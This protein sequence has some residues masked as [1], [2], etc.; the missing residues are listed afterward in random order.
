MIN[1]LNL[2]ATKGDLLNRTISHPTEPNVE[3]RTDQELE[4]SFNKVLPEILGGF[5][6]VIVKALKVRETVKVPKLF[7][8]ADFTQWGCALAVA[9]GETVEDFIEAMEENLAYQN[10]ADIENNV[11][12]DAFLSYCIEKLSLLNPTENK[13]LAAPPEKVFENVTS[14]AESMKIAT[15]S[16]R[17]PSA[18]CYFT[19]KLNDSKA[20][21]V[22]NHWNYEVAKNK[23]GK[24]EMSIWRIQE[25]PKEADKQEEAKAPEAQKTIDLPKEA[26]KQYCRE[27]CEN[28]RDTGCKKPNA[29]FAEKI[30]LSDM[31]EIP[32]NPLCEGFKPKGG[33]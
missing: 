5:L 26:P 6:D 9:L 18:A 14:Q 15:K 7:R 28:F 31:A 10:M 19:R 2:P 29:M 24:R 12:A 16:K 27:E 33:T 1:G 3:R 11:V 13:P 4:A 21:I 22:A 30:K 23:E 32:Q 8:L 25:K 20:A 17:W